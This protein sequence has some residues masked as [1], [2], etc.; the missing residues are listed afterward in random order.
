LAEGLKPGGHSIK[1]FGDAVDAGLTVDTSPAPPLTGGPIRT[2]A[3]S[4]G[5]R[6]DWMTPGGGVQTTLL[7][8]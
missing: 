2:Q 3:T 4:A 6:V 7:P 1:V 5:L 8:S